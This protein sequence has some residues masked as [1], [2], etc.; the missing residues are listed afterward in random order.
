MIN[1][2]SYLTL[3]AG[4]LLTA[5]SAGCGNQMYRQP[6]YTPLDA[7]RAAP[8]QE[9]VAA[10]NALLPTDAR[11]VASIAYG[12][13][14]KLPG[15]AEAKAVGGVH[16]TQFPS[17]EPVLPPPN[18]SDN[19]RYE[20]APAA[21]DALK[22]PLPNDPRVVRSGQILFYNRCVQCHNPSGYGYGT[23]GQYLIPHPPDLAAPLVQNIT[24]GA[25]FWHITMGQGKMPG[26]R[27]WTT[28]PERWAMVSYVRSLKGGKDVQDAANPD[29]WK[30]SRD[31]PYPTYG[32]KDFQDGYSANPFKTL[33]PPVEGSDMHSAL[34]H[35]GQGQQPA[36]QAP[37]TQPGQ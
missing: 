27:H 14:V 7:P 30:V 32:V 5:L 19:A 25:I 6:N 16:L 22:N 17:K 26:F 11:P 28:P 31:A 8:P 18:L 2:R 13:R 15:E 29:A 12:A 20:P 4:S 24:D 36:T 33:S 10:D 1:T 21:V 37:A 34:T 3:L 35:Q 23:V 9:A